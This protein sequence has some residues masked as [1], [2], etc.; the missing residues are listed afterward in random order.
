MRVLLI[1]DD[2]AISTVIKRGLEEEERFCTVQTATDGITGL[3]LARDEDFAVIILDVMLPGMDGWRICSELRNQRIR[4]PILML[5]A[6]DSVQDRVRGL[7]TGA[8]D[9]LTKPFDFEELLA[10]VRALYRR[11]KVN[12]GRVLRIAHLEI[13]TVSRHVTCEGEEVLLTPREYALLETLAQHEGHV[14]SRDT[15]LYRVWNADDSTSNTVD[16][17]IGVLRK[18]IDANH[19][20]KLIHTVH[21]LGYMLKRPPVETSV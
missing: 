16:V 9:Y 11:D 12:K 2:A 7:D 15:I 8:D 6:R 13:D 18:K 17:H 3:R 5:T 21:G 14:V 20:V 10:R 1:E 19:S 4:T